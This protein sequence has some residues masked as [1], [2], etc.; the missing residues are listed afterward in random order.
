LG[1]CF[2]RTV[3]PK[4]LKQPIFVLPFSAV[5][6]MYQFKQEMAWVT[7]WAIFSKTHLATLVELHSSGQRAKDDKVGPLHSW[8]IEIATCI[9]FLTQKATCES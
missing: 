7:F 6:I 9:D 5:I 4:S 8:T 3:F 1:D 2:L